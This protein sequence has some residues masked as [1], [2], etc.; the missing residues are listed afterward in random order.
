[1]ESLLVQDLLVNMWVSV[2][3]RFLPFSE[4]VSLPLPSHLRALWS[5]P[6]VHIGLTFRQKQQRKDGS[7]SRCGPFAEF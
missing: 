2:C 4:H 5:F 3:F 7:M 1:M 6:V